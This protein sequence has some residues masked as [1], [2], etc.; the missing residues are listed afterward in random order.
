MKEN[1]L[2]NV[3]QINEEDKRK[4]NIVKIVVIVIIFLL[5]AILG[6]LY[7]NN[8]KVQDFFDK[9]IFRKDIEENNLPSILTEEKNAVKAYSYNG[10]ILTLN[11]NVLSVYNEYAKEEYN[12]NIEIT[13]PIFASEGKYLCIAERGGQKVYLISGE[14]II[15]Q[16]NLEGEI[17]DISINKHGYIAVNVEGESYKTIIEV[18]DTDGNGLFN[19]FLSSTYVIDTSITSDNKYLAIA[20]VDFSGIM[21]QSNI[22]IVSIEKAM[23]DQE[24]DSIE[25]T[26]TATEGDLIINIEYDNENILSCIYDN[27]ITKIENNEE[28]IITNF[29]NENVLFA[30]LNDDIIKVVKN[31]NKEIDLQIINAKTGEITNYKIEE[32]KSIY[33]YEDVT[34]INLGTEVLFINNNGWLIKRYKSSQ[35]INNIVLS[36]NIAGIVYSNKIELISL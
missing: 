27:K 14:R 15:W 5:I 9:Y 31:E 13:N 34:A 6:T 26:Y 17:A 19:M 30:D 1:K 20:E 24:K 36:N 32:P 33:T 35:E 22:E 28:T 23:A 3:K 29:N 21:V 2:N 7:E 11:K 25:Y 10:K 8:E 4:R 18:F 12:L 16:R